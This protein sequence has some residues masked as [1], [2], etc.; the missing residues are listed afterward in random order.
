MKILIMGGFLGA[1]KTSVVLQLAK[2]IV[3]ENPDKPAKVVIVENEI[4]EVSID[5][6]VLRSGGYKVEGLFSGCVCCTMSGELVL[7]VMNI[8]REMEPDWI[9]MEATG[10]AYPKNVKETLEKSILDAD[11][12]ICC[13]ADARRWKRLLKP[14]GLLLRDQL[15]GADII[16][17]NKVEELDEAVVKEVMDS[18]K[19]FNS[20]A[21]YYCISALRGIDKKVL[22]GILGRA[23]KE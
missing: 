15:S 2:H 9:I 23:E 5:D 8:K 6:K 12:R 1:G 19:T 7:T 13:V 22:D 21:E 20:S 4:G 3:G 17:V 18:V 11:I 10:V 14:M 16:L